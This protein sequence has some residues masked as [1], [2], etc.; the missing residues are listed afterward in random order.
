MKKLLLISL[1]AI[2]FIQAQ[3]LNPQMLEYMNELRAEAKQQNPNFQEFDYARGEKIFTKKKMGK[4]GTLISCVTCHTN[5]LSKNG[6][7]EK[8]NKVIEPLS[9][10]ANPQ[11]FT[12]VKEVTKWLRRNFRDVYDREG[13][14][15]EKGDVITYIINMYT[16][17]ITS[18][19]KI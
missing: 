14:A 4:N 16:K 1:I 19:G 18:L 2:S 6:L 13:T 9:P 15:E 7:N 10:H 11:R 5:D 17:D 3:E 8:T 12:E